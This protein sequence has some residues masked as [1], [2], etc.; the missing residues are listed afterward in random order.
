MKYELKITEKAKYEVTESYIYYEKLQTGLGEEFL[1]HLETFFN[2]SK[3]IQ[4]IFLKR[5]LLIVKHF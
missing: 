1:S 3:L 5:K 2:E 4:S